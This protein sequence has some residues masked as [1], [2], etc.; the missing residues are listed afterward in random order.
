MK[1]TRTRRIVSRV[2]LAG[3][4]A[5]VPVAAVAVPAFAATPSA[6]AV[7][8]HNQGPDHRGPG[9]DDHRHDGPRPQG[10]QFPQFPQGP[11]QFLPSTGSAG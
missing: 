8:W 2:A 1:T 3:A 5:V 11:Q 10:P 6:S 7:D 9:D 4:L